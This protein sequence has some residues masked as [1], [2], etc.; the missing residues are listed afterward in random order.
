MNTTELEKCLHLM[1]FYK[2]QDKNVIT[3][4]LRVDT[5]IEKNYIIPF[6]KELNKNLLSKDTRKAKRDF[7]RFYISEFKGLQKHYQFNEI[8]HNSD[9]HIGHTDDNEIVRFK[10][11][12]T[13]V[14]KSEFESYVLLGLGLFNVLF[15]KIQLCCITYDLDFLNLCNKLDFSTEL[16]DIEPTLDFNKKKNKDKQTEQSEEETGD[17]N[18][19]TV[20][21]IYNWLFEFKEA[22]NAD[23]DYQEAVNIIY[24]YFNNNE[25]KVTSQ[26]FVKS[27]YTK[28][29]AYALGDLWRKKK[30]EPITFEYLSLYKQL[31]SIFSKHRLE[32]KHVFSSPLYKYSITKT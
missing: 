15:V 30:N 22:F 5:E 26:I 24:S 7:I 4:M 13:G 6:T 14:I 21:N 27:G 16:I 31:F 32:K 10:S 9:A 1:S 20:S 28:R 3:K 11:I 23:A 12:S 8:C 2:N 29:L 19:F 17:D 25:Y 18:N